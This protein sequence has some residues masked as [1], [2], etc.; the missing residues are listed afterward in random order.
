[1]IRII[2]VD[3]EELARDRLR[4]MLK[5]Y[6]HVQIIGEAGDGEQAIE[7]I[8]EREPDLVFLDI[9]MPGCSGIEVA[10]SLPAERPQIIFCT[11]YDQY[12]I[13]AFELHAAD[14]L[15]KPVSRARLARALEKVMAGTGEESSLEGAVSGMMPNRFLGKRKNRFYVIPLEEV[16]YFGSEGGLTQMWTRKQ[17]FWMEPTLNE[18]EKR[19]ERGGF[20]RIS[21]QALVNLD[22]IAQVIPLIG[23]HGM[24]KLSNGKELQVSRRRMKPLIERL[25]RE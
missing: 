8:L 20:F 16:L 3:D 12:A 1:M 17:Y 25:E 7:M 6:P 22:E 23:G 18:L 9:Q 4:S 5:V 2:L 24:I 13:E 11:A 19:L 15:L 14:Y 21:R 10:A